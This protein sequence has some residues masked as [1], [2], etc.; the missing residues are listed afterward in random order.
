M[1]KAILVRDLVEEGQQLLDQLRASR[2]PISSAFWYFFEEEVLWRLIIASP[3]VE[4]E[5]P[6]KAYGRIQSAL[7][8]IRPRTLTLQ[9]VSV[10]RPNSHQFRQL[11]DA[12]R[13]TRQ[14][15]V[16]NPAS[17]PDEIWAENAVIYSK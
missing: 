17:I 6:L 8:K 4:T 12:L 11:R 10:M 14:M 16:R 3:K 15:T 9:N 5:G 2:F 1:Y 13:H 7:A